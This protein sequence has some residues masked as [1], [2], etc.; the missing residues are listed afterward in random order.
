MA[1]PPSKDEPGE[2]DEPGPGHNSEAFKEKLTPESRDNDP[3]P[4]LNP[5]PLVLPAVEGTE[6]SRIIEGE[7]IKVP[8]ANEAGDGY[9]SYGAFK[10][11][12]KS[13][14]AGYEW[15]HIVRSM[16]KISSVLAR[17][18]FTIGTISYVCPRKFIG[19]LAENML[20]SLLSQEA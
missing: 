15:H 17:I 13:A 16:R 2:R 19:E 10:W 12:Y 9:G 6:R 14:R 8:L 7:D 18:R 5:A 20:R 11:K 1:K 3:K 4:P